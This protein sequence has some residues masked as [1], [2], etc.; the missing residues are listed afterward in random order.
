[1]V[2]YRQFDDWLTRFQQLGY[3]KAFALFRQAVV[4][5]GREDLERAVI[6]AHAGRPIDFYQEAR[7]P[8]DSRV[9][10]G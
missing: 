6:Q 8:F 3:G 7:F 2:A 4:D 1:L 5:H 9:P 10:D